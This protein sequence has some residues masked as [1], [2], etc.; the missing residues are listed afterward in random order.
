MKTINE[1]PYAFFVEGGWG[2]LGGGGDVRPVPLA[3]PSAPSP[4][5]PALTPSAFARSQDGA[6]DESDSASEF[7]ADSDVGEESSASS[8]DG[9]AFD[10]GASDDEGS[11]ASDVSEGESWDELESKALKA[12]EKKCV[13]RRLCPLS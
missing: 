13:A 6:S 2:F 7:D 5:L 12:D 10:E 3:S 9:S 4:S 11:A 8:D 1:D